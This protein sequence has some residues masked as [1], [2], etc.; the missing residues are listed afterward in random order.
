[1]AAAAAATVMVMCGEPWGVKQFSD[2]S[3]VIQQ[4]HQQNK[5]YLFT[6]AAVF[7]DVCMIFFFGWL[8]GWFMVQSQSHYKSI[9]TVL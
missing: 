9:I 7:N 8:A 6:V 1:M 4:Q 5:K 3:D 2:H